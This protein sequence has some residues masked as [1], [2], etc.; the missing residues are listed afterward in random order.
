MMIGSTTVRTRWFDRLQKFLQKNLADFLGLVL[1]QDFDGF[2][3]FGDESVKVWLTQ[4]LGHIVSDFNGIL[5]ITNIRDSKVTSITFIGLSE[6][7]ERVD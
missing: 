2:F 7:L 6:F 4:T 1:R 5:D 3:G